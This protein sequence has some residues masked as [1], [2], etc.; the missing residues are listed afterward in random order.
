MHLGRA[1][2][3]AV[4]E[5]SGISHITMYLALPAMTGPEVADSPSIAITPAAS[6][7]DVDVD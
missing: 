4:I 7:I 2:F 6:K 1:S 3:I 5:T